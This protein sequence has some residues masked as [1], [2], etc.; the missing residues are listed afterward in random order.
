MISS[1]DVRLAV[2][3]LRL[4][5]GKTQ[6]D[7]AREIGKSIPTVQR[8]EGLVPPAGEA[9]VQ[10]MKLADA[11]GHLDLAAIFQRAISKELGHQIPRFSFSEDSTFEI[12]PG[13]RIEFEA[14]AS[15]LRSAEFEEE[16]QEW[17]R[18]SD[19]VKASGAKGDAKAAATFALRA[20]IRRR[21]S[22]GEPDNEIVSKLSA[23]PHQMIL[24]LAYEERQLDR[25][26]SK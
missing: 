19:P 16:R 15:I 2:K 14:L 18:I 26:E 12:L 17:R 9:L 24:M 7:F 22:A 23:W 1:D 10:F 21:V 4:L 6:A 13:E 20:E 25:E 8:Y 3:K 11:H 5:L